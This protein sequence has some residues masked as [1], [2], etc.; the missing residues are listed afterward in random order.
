[1]KSI[2]KLSLRP[3][4]TIREALRIIDTGASRIALVTDED[5]K[6][7]GTI[8][9]GDIRRAILR[10]KSLDDHI[11]EVYFKDPVVVSADTSKEAIVNLCTAKKLYQIPVVDDEGRVIR[12]AMLDEILKPE[13][14]PNKVVLMVGGLGTRLRPLT[15]TTPKPL[16]HVGGKP[17]LQTIVERFASYGFTDI[18]M[19]VNYKAEMI[20]DHFGDGSRFG[21]TIEYITESKRMGTA[22]ALSLLPERPEEPFFVMNGDLLTSVN[23]ENMLQYHIQNEAKASMC[24]R[25]YDLQVPYGVVHIEKGMI[26]AIEEKPVHRFFVSAGIYMLDPSCLDLIPKGEYYDMPSLFEELIARDEKAVSFPLREYWLDIGRME[27]YER[28]NREY[29]EVFD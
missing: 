27:E 1:M 12:V 19:C 15:E 10:G 13:R 23:F 26:R 29:F 3:D 8:T 28:A 24:V 7:L 18:V 14:Y 11:E 16:L 6:L 22:G 20:R 21:V 4:A 17:I 25:E 5:G 9:D 2:E